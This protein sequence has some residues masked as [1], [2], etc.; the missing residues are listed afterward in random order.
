MCGVVGARAFVPYVLQA[1]AACHTLEKIIK[2]IFNS[3]R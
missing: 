2:I 3:S 1:G